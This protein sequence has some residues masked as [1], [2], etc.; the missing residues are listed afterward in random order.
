MT[1]ATIPE[2]QRGKQASRTFS[3]GPLLEDKP[4][5]K[6]PACRYTG[7]RKVVTEGVFSYE[8]AITYHGF[9][10]PASSKCRL[11]NVCCLKM[12]GENS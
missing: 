1:G 12:S 7:N 10:V 6:A 5:E 4:L 2:K 11:Q 8:L 9:A 3:F